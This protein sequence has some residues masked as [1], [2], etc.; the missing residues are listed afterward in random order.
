MLYSRER[1]LLVPA[2]SLELEKSQSTGVANIK[3][4]GG[5]NFGKQDKFESMGMTSSTMIIE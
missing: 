2:P 4:T 3:N 1:I 5:Q